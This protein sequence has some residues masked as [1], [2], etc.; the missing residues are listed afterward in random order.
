MRYCQFIDASVLYGSVSFCVVTLSGVLM[1]DITKLCYKPARGVVVSASG[2][3]LVGREF[4]AG[5]YQDLINSYCSLLTRRTVCRRVAWN[6]TRKPNKRDQI[7]AG[8]VQ[9]Q[10]WRYKTTVVIKRH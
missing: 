2:S 8:F 4:S 7:K 1:L 6:T 9:T 3:V 10:S 5:T